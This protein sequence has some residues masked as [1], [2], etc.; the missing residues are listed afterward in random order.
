MKS[1]IFS[2]CL[3][4]TT[5]PL[6]TYKTSC[7]KVNKWTS[8]CICCMRTG[9]KMKQSVIAKRKYIPNT[10]EAGVWGCKLKPC[11]CNMHRHREQPNQFPGKWI[12]CN[13]VSEMTNFHTEM[14]KRKLT[15]AGVG[16]SLSLPRKSADSHTGPTTSKVATCASAAGGETSS[17]CCM[18][19]DHA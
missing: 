5:D 15:S 3:I 6:S 17:M 19:C 13:N 9:R 18:K 4:F 14:R 1:S 2:P 7:K 11:S 16:S 10:Q 8:A 12:C